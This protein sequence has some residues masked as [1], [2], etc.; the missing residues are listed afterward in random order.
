MAVATKTK[1]RIV[2][3]V[4]PEQ[5]QNL[6]LAAQRIYKSGQPVTI[7]NLCKETDPD[8][9]L[10]DAGKN[11][12]NSTM[13]TLKKKLGGWPYDAQGNAIPASEL[14]F[15]LV[16]PDGA[17]GTKGASATGSRAIAGETAKQAAR[18]FVHTLQAAYVELP[19]EI[20]ARVKDAVRT[21]EDIV[22]QGQ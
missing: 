9:K 8:G 2:V 12:V 17:T 21:L 15:T 4:L 22:M 6:M 19:F 18:E 14:P 20:Q 3:E 5:Q 10:T 11:R 1:N 13:G 16:W 7:A